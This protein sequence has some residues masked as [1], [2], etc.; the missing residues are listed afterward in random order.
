MVITVNIFLKKIS[1]YFTRVQQIDET[2]SGSY[3]LNSQS[4]SH[5]FLHEFIRR[6]KLRKP[7]EFER[8]SYFFSQILHVNQ[9]F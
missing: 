5:N 3:P 4:W 1:T 9:R 8:L 7:M 6:I 2:N